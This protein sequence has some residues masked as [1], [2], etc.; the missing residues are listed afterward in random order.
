MIRDRLSGHFGGTSPGAFGSQNVA[1][2]GLL[3]H[4][5]NG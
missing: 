2:V 5:D 1:D 4:L 3:R